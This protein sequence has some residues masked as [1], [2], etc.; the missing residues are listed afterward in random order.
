MAD[1]E[2][3]ALVL[4][5]EN[6]PSGVAGIVAARLAEQY[7]RPVFVAC[8]DGEIARG[9][10]RGVAGVHLVGLLS[11]LSH[12]LEAF[13][14]HELA[15]GFT[16]RREHLALFKQS[17]IDQCSTL[18]RGEAVLDI[19][20]EIDP[21]WADL[22]GLHALEALAPFGTGFSQPVFAIRGMVATSVIQ[23]GGGKH[24]RLVFERGGRRLDAVWFHR[25]DLPRGQRLDIA[26]RAEINRFRGQEQVQLRLIDARESE[27]TADV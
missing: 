10:A 15:A 21:E 6:W 20:A 19:D 1:I 11:N 25:T 17:V 23:M 14:G 26:F 9:S 27:V 3:P 4:T 12:L 8:L 7:E 22:D 2:A 13:G 5:G 24:L 16:V 18:P